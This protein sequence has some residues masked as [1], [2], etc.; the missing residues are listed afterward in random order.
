MV[1]VAN[2]W[3]ETGGR[4]PEV[5]KKLVHRL[6]YVR[7]LSEPKQGG[8]GWDMKRG[9]EACRGNYISVID[10]DGQFPLEAVFS[11]FAKIRSEQLDMVKTYRV[12]RYDGFYR[13]FIS[14]CYNL[15]FRI[16]FPKYRGYRDVNGKPK[17]L[18]KEIYDKMDLHSDDW[19]LDAE[20]VL[21]V[22][23]LNL[24]IGEIPVR[25]KS[26][27]GRKSFLKFSAIFEFVKNLI[28]YRL[29]YND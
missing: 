25:F 20:I 21:N 27:E 16:L 13:I 1:L 11:C 7:Y 18:R 6:P 24:S 2:Y 23:R 8:M 26:L 12:V 29:R 10:G 3:P 28:K 4:T 17:I 14:T 5:V 9:M 19:F 22:L 15:I